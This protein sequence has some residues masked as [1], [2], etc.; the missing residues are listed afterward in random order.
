MTPSPGQGR[1]EF[2]AF[3]R[4]L[5]LDDMRRI[6]GGCVMS[7]AASRPVGPSPS[8]LRGDAAPVQ[9]RLPEVV[10]LDRPPENLPGVGC[11]WL[12]DAYGCDAHLLRSLPA[13]IEVCERVVA[14]VGL[15]VCGPPQWRRFPE[16]GGVTG[17]YL[18]SESHLS[19]HTWPEHGLAAFNLFCCQ[20][21]RDWAWS[22]RLRDCLG[23]TDV[24]VRRVER[25]GADSREPAG[26]GA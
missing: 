16:P 13:M 11:E 17:L 18:L 24:R 1:M 14:E 4:P 23:A 9:P 25:G 22:E 8:P 20:R 10:R 7:F 15:T 19:C 2:P 21:R 3:R 6:D 26:G 12:I 5:W